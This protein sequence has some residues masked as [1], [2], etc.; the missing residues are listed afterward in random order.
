MLNKKA[1]ELSLN[2]MVVLVISIVIFGF[3][4]RFMSSL[5]SEADKLKDLTYEQIDK[6][7]SDIVCEGTEMVC[8]STDRK[9]IQRKNYGVFDIR[10]LNVLDNP[11]FDAVVLTPSPVGYSKNNNPINGPGLIAIPESRSVTIEKNGEKKIGVG[12]EVPASAVSGTYIFN[13]KITNPESQDTD[14]L[15][16]PLQKL[17]VDVP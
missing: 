12:I 17:Y 8:I 15:Y 16:V 7:I 6:K 13:V 1:I 14:K 4:I 9:K 5:F 2:F 11:N 3:G 10:I